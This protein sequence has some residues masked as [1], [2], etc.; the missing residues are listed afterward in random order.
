V[1][2]NG[3]WFMVPTEVVEEVYPWEDFE[4][5]ATSVGWTPGETELSDGLTEGP[6]DGI[7]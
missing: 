4:L 2:P 3:F 6:S 7:G 5:I 1:D